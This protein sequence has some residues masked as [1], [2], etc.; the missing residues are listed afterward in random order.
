MT[1]R[2]RIETV[3]SGAMP[4]RL[5]FTTRL[6]IW[7]NSRLRTGTLPE[8]FVGKSLNEVHEYIGVGRQAYTLITPFKLK[9]VDCR[10]VYEGE[11]V[12]RFH[13]PV[14]QFPR[15]YSLV[16]REKP[17]R[18]EITFTCP[19]GTLICVY[20]TTQ[21][22]LDSYSQPYLEKHVLASDEDYAPVNWILE[23]GEPVA[24]FEKFLSL[25][26]EIGENGMVVGTVERIPFQRL[27]LD[28]MGEERC[29]YQMYDNAKAFHHV[30]DQLTEM[31]WACLEIAC[32]SSS[33]IVE[34]VDNLDGF[35]TN[36]NLFKEYSLPIMQQTA[37]KIHAAGKYFAS[38]VD[39]D[40][41]P[42][43]DLLPE[44]GL[45]V[46]ESFSP[47]PL[48]R[49][50]FKEAYAVWKKKPVMWGVLP[51]PL[52]EDRVPE[53]TFR[54]EIRDI[55]DSIVADSPAIMGVADQAIGLTLW[56][57]VQEVSEMI[58]ALKPA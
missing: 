31:H 18:T 33:L 55:L 54:S 34:C 32:S 39:G 45:D 24:D 58:K 23:N 6:E 28:F 57:R 35:M 53:G 2:K 44:T 51:S 46:A 41:L 4:D 9:G 50:T 19:A 5:P 30:L 16:P 29:F 11:E 12:S 14:F 49:L 40:I 21:E 56:E 47:S 52:F 1:E 38:H 22:I 26:S 27:L 8:R 15:I 7:Y 17:G 48:S 10:V 13:E 3:L 25:E 36:P 37:D 42:L 20:R 43:V